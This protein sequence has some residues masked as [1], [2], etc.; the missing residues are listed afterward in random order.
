[1]HITAIAT[2]VL[3]TSAAHGKSGNPAREHNLTVCMELVPTLSVTIGQAQKIASRM[4]A[5]VGVMI[6]WRSGFRGCPAQA[7]Q[8]SI[9]NR[10]PENLR[11]G[12]LAYARPYE[13][14]DIQLFYDRIAAAG[15][16]VLVPRL[17]A[18]VLVHEITHI[19]EQISRHSAY[20]IM[21]AR[22]DREDYVQ[23]KLMPLP[24]AAEDIDLIRKGLAARA[25][26]AMVAPR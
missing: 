1:M 7:I 16:A 12:A 14:A 4:F 6:N 18:H 15:D 9:S 26:G 5:P 10:T 25:P 21:K 13:G 23:M 24:F 20:G 19:L 3:M 11:P 22:W 17:M 2:M 8:V